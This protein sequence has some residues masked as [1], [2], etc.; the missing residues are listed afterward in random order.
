MATQRGNMS[1]IFAHIPI[2]EGKL[3]NSSCMLEVNVVTGDRAW[4]ETTH[5]RPQQWSSNIHCMCFGLTACASMCSPLI[6][7]EGFMCPAA[8]AHA[9]L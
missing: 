9:M 7:S 1:C 8:L 2:H 4:N 3:H 5:Q 6:A